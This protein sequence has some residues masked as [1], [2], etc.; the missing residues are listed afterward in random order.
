MRAC[1]APWEPR[2]EAIDPPRE[3]RVLQ[4]ENTSEA[5]LGGSISFLRL[6]YITKYHRLSG[7]KQQEC[8]S[9]SSGGWKSEIKGLAGR[10]VLSLKTLGKALLHDALP[11]SGGLKHSLACRCIS[12]LLRLLVAFSVSSHRLP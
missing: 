7:S 6:P 11:A 8:V 3:A 12:P 4:D 2:E 5:S 10:T 9:Y 1:T